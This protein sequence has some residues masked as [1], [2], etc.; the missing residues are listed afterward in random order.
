MSQ[1]FDKLLQRRAGLA[2]DHG[3]SHL[4]QLAHKRGVGDDEQLGMALGLSAQAQSHVRPDGAAQAPVG[5]IDLKPGLAK[6]LAPCDAIDEKNTG[7]ERWLK[8]K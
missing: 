2:A 7:G 4:S 8:R 6:E 1:V 5:G 3:L